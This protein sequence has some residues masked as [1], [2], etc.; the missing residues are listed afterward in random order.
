MVVG[1]TIQT[2]E[3]PPMP[4][5]TNAQFLFPSFDRRKFEAYLE[6]GNVSSDGGL[7]APASARRASRVDQGFFTRVLPD[8]RHPSLIS[9]SQEVLLRQRIFG[10]AKGYEDLND[11]DTLRHDLLLQG[12]AHNGRLERW[13]KFC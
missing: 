6:A 1:V 10:R 9:H 7:M 5:C 3:T 8:D 4:N 11:H 2:K 13:R 12:V